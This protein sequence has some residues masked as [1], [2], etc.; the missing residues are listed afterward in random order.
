MCYYQ[1]YNSQ[2][3]NFKAACSSDED[4]SPVAATLFSG[5]RR[6]FQEPTLL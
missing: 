3:P 2:K 6:L 4:L 5:F 1:Q